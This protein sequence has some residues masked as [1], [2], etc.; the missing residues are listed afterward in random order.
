VGRD[1]I[2]VQ[3]CEFWAPRSPFIQ[4]HRIA[5]AAMPGKGS[6]LGIRQITL[7]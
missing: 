2:T 4:P 5:G 1:L 3:S 6:D 7:R